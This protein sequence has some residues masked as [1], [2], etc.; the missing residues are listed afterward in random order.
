MRNM[1]VPSRLIDFYRQEAKTYERSRHG[2]IYGTVF[3]GLHYE[4]L[5]R[6]LDDCRSGRVLEVAAGT[7]HSSTLLASLGLELTCVDLTIE[8]LH[9]AK[10]NLTTHGLKATFL[11][12]NGFDL[13][14][15]DGT[16]Q[17]AVATRFFHLWER[18]QQTELLKETVRVLRPGGILVVDFDNF[19][20][21]FLLTPAIKVYKW[22]VRKD[23]N[24]SENF[25]KLSETK[26]LLEAA[27]LRVVD[28]DGVGGYFLAVPSLISAKLGM[29]FGRI[30][31]RRPF[32]CCAEQFIIKS[33]KL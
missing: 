27:G 13:P 6:M 21:N 30:M 14:F 1:K 25:N 12:G 24:I 20:H 22:C 7:G 15:P 2:G 4:A 18:D 26:Q 9:E 28:I 16:F 5:Y 17:F 10:H 8:M 31:Y 23:R 29:F 32:V 19:L 3:K 11:L 33:Q